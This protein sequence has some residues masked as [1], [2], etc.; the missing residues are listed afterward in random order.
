MDVPY[1]ADTCLSEIHLYSPQAPTRPRKTHFLSAPGEEEGPQKKKP[2]AGLQDLAERSTEAPPNDK[3]SADIDLID[4]TV[5]GA[6]LYSGGKWYSKISHEATSIHLGT[7]DSQREAAV[8]FDK[9]CLYLK[10]RDADLNFSLSDYLDARG[11][12]VEDPSIRERID[13][14]LARFGLERWVAFLKSDV[15]QHAGLIL[16]FRPLHH[17]LIPLASVAFLLFLV[18]PQLLYVGLFIVHWFLLLN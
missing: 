7:Y 11:E 13:L 2:R 1:W 9:A 12:I 8:A 16:H 5:R 10:G 17:L 4:L 3:P 14:C 18:Q 6:Y 15:M